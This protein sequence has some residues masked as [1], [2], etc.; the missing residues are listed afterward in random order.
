MLSSLGTYDFT[1]Y[2]NLLTKVEETDAKVSELGSELFKRLDLNIQSEWKVGYELAGEGIYSSSA[3]WISSGNLYVEDDLYY[4][5]NASKIFCYDSN[6]A[7][8]DRV[9]SGDQLIDGTAFVRINWK[10]SDEAPYFVS[11]KTLTNI[12][13]EAKSE[14][15]ESINEAKSEL[16]E[17]KIK[18]KNQNIQSEWKV[19]YE[20]AGGGI[21]SS[22]ADWIS[23]GNLY[24]EDDL[25]YESNASKFFCYDSNGAY[26]DR[27]YS[28]DQL[29]DGTAFVRINWKASDEAPYF[30]SSKT[31][32]N[33]INEA[34]SELTESVGY[35]TDKKITGNLKPTSGS[36]I[37][38]FTTNRSIYKLETK[39]RLLSINGLL[40]VD[41]ESIGVEESYYADNCK[42]NIIVTCGSKQQSIPLRINNYGVDLFSIRAR[43]PIVNS[44]EID[45]STHIS[46]NLPIELESCYLS[47]T[48][49]A[50]SIHYGDDSILEQY[51]L[52]QFSDVASLVDA[53]IAS[54]TLSEH[55]VVEK[56]G[57]E[58]V[59]FEEISNF[60]KIY[61]VRQHTEYLYQQGDDIPTP[62]GETYWDSYPTM[63][64]TNDVGFKHH[65]N[66]S[67]KVVDGYVK[68]LHFSLD[69]MF[70]R[71]ETS[72]EL[73]KN[74]MSYNS[75]LMDY[76][77]YSEYPYTPPITPLL[78][79][80]HWVVESDNILGQYMKTTTYRLNTILSYLSQL[81]FVGQNFH[82]CLDTIRGINKTDVQTYCLTFD[83]YQKS[84]WTNEVIR[85]IFN[86]Y[87]A[88][89]TLVYIING[90]DLGG[91][92]PPSSAPTQEEYKQMKSSG[93]NIIPHGFTMYISMMSYA[94]FVYGFSQTQKKWIDW[95][96][97]C[98]VAYN[99]HGDEPTDY[100]YYILRSLGFNLITSG[101][102]PLG[103]Y[104]EAG[105]TINIQ[106]KRITWLDSEDSW[107]AVKSRIDQ[108]I[109]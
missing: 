78:S 22:S 1:D 26:I 8:I 9:Y 69:G 33:I 81:G 41:I 91:D 72:I 98:P 95:Y 5:S 36:L 56:Y 20:L 45:G 85:K 7:Y 87:N 24:V 107:G 23:S 50:I 106:Y 70:V 42:A 66:V 104:C 25:Y 105:T 62:T 79:M 19:G 34:K 108:Y 76:A 17:F 84:L 86:K 65:M 53:M 2:S 47:K 4:K 55:F 27:V 38:E 63:I 92:T 80:Q 48:S 93:W 82:E 52:S 60:D 94:Q 28:G 32:T 21:Y 59:T 18:E 46:K 30:V 10:A 3:D 51:V 64:K 14:L 71:F 101:S 67:Y 15:T 31:L 102:A 96:G 100:Q 57:C 109:H 35:Q 11:S 40:S 13:N 75:D 90:A 74:T 88:K 68:K 99:A 77:T 44:V 97:E 37:F 54:T 61:L 6:G 58:G 89:P 49:E 103:W 73:N 83:D 43:Y 29:I 12:I 16:T 39:E